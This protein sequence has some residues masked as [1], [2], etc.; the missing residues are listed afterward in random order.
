MSCWCAESRQAHALPRGQCCCYRDWCERV[1]GSEHSKGTLALLHGISLILS[2][3]ILV[4]Q[5]VV[6]T[7]YSHVLT[8]KT[9]SRRLFS[10]FLYIYIYIY[11]YVFKS[12]SHFM[13]CPMQ[14]NAKIN[15]TQ[16]L[17]DC[18]YHGIPT[19]TLGKHSSTNVTN[20]SPR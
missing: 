2:I 16:H 3:N 12:C 7:I 19:Q 10:L 17:L 14:L 8:I 4:V 13:Q 18:L 15:P 20:S 5:S 11:I 6:I 9:I 1:G